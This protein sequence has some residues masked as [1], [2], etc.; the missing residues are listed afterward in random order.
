MNDQYP[1]LK[2]FSRD[3][4][5]PEENLVSAF[6]VEREFHLRILSEKDWKVRKQLYSEV[7]NRVHRIYAKDKLDPFAKN[8]KDRIV[9]LF[10]KELAGKSILDI[11]CGNGHF[12][13]SVDKQLPHKKLVGIDISTAVLPQHE[14]T[15][16][17]ITSDIIDF[18]LNE[19]FEVAFSDNV[20]E[21]I[22][23]SDLGTH[24]TSVRKAL[25][26]DGTLILIMPN[27][28][29]GPS[30]V[31]RIIDYTYSNKV[32]ACGTHVNESTYTELIPLLTQFGFKKFRTVLPIPRLK[33]L[34][35]WLR[36]HTDIILAIE[37]SPLLLNNLYAIRYKSKCVIKL[38][39]VLICNA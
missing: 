21:H 10:S 37:N 30:D 23:P 6:E 28:L 33:F 2:I 11:G 14:G 38:D 26:P 25:R 34:A 35:P 13:T 12:L 5:I 4:G 1:F 19:Q 3:I 16:R 29:F 39:I 32:Q 31:T 15:M 8:P 36:I 27:R 24:L 17:F 20:I 9:R 7:Y 22:A 18:E